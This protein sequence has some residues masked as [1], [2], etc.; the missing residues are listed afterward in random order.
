[1]GRH[2]GKN[3]KYPNIKIIVVDKGGSGSAA[4][5]VTTKGGSTRLADYLSIK[6][7]V[8]SNKKPFFYYDQGMG[9]F[10]GTCKK[11]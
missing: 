1:M 9:Y 3:N 4:A 7:W 11:K 10:T 2:I 8:K 5:I 6:T